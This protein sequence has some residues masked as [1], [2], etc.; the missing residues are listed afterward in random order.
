MYSNGN[1]KMIF[2]LS[3]LI[4]LSIWLLLCVFEIT[5]AY[6][7]FVRLN[8]NLHGYESKLNKYIAALIRIMAL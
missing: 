2:Y 1:I 4:V 8:I 3:S 7:Q 5:R 6:T